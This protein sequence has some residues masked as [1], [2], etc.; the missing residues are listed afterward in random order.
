MHQKVLNVI[1]HYPGEVYNISYTPLPALFWILFVFSLAPIEKEIGNLI[2]DIGKERNGA[3]IMQ[4]RI[5]AKEIAESIRKRIAAGE[6]LVGDVVPSVREMAHETGASTVT[7]NHAFRI[8]TQEKMIEAVPGKG[9]FVLES[10]IAKKHL[11]V[12]I[13]DRFRPNT[14]HL[15]LPLLDLIPQSA[16]KYFLEH[17]CRVSR[18]SADDII[19]PSCFQKYI[20]GLDGIIANLFSVAEI[21]NDVTAS[22]IQTVSYLQDFVHDFPVSQIVLEH[23]AAMDSIVRHVLEEK[24]PEVFIIADDYSN[25]IARK[26][27][28]TEAFARHSPSGVKITEILTGRKSVISDRTL[29]NIAFDLMKRIPGNLVFCTS[30]TIAWP[31]LRTFIDLKLI[32]GKDFFFV[33]YD[34]SE[35]YGFIPFGHPMMTS[36]DSRMPDVGRRAARLLIDRIR[37]PEN[38]IHIVRLPVSLVIRETAFMQRTSRKNHFHKDTEKKGED[39]YVF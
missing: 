13:I 30:D 27:A 29:Y 10:P 1:C 34:N 2:I 7:A 8:L 36:I 3:G 21:L 39:A 32:P 17:G 4:D 35:A 20:D 11:H 24:I 23:T 22:G 5:T 38:E 18:I 25:G 16:E 12:G 26:N 15:D 33:S 6:F 14:T 37:N 28:L 31:V 19:Q 9:S